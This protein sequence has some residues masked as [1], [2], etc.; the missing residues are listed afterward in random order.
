MTTA[1]TRHFE[2]LSDIRVSD[3][4]TTVLG[5]LFSLGEAGLSN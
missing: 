4:R 1:E 3:L 2:D 5:I